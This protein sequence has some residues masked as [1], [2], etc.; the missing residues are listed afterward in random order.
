MQPIRATHRILRTHEGEVAWR[1]QALDPQ[2]RT[3]L[4]SLRNS[5]TVSELLHSG[6]WSPYDLESALNKLARSGWVLI[7]EQE[8]PTEEND[9]VDVVEV[10]SS[11]DDLE[12]LLS[13]HRLEEELGDEGEVVP[14]STTDESIVGAASGVEQRIPSGSSEVVETR[15]LPKAPRVREEDNIAEL[16]FDPSRAADDGLLNALRNP[17]AS[18]SNYEQPPEW[19]PPSG[20]LAALL[21]ALGESVPD[22]VDL[23]PDQQE[24]LRDL[25][26]LEP[27]GGGSSP[28]PA[29][30]EKPD[31]TPFA[32]LRDQPS[33]EGRQ[34]ARL[35]ALHESLGKVQQEQAQANAARDRA[36]Q[37][38]AERE[39]ALKKVHAEQASR[40]AQEE[41]GRE[42]STLIGLSQKLARVKNKNAD[43]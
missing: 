28:S 40:R 39:A 10:S 6:G 2:V 13:R 8:A 5:Q 23:S 15:A 43:E 30:T 7:Q 35:G 3:L 22:G 11:I 36:R 33:S 31:N 38:R 24:H 12:A 14:P 1:T 17:E 34:R 16:P 41:R 18:A 4:G 20:G 19:A 25:A 32:R 42:G 27:W 9:V 37:V 29:E 21:R 26:P